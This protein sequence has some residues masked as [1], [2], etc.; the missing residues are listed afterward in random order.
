M[1]RLSVV[2]FQS[3][4]GVIQSVLSHDED[5]DGGFAHGGWVL[6]YIDETVADFMQRQTVAAGGLLL[7]R[8]TYEAF[9][10]VW[11]YADQ[12]EPAV[13][14]MNQIPKYV[15]STTLT[16]TSWANTVVLGRDVPAEVARLKKSKGGDLVVFGSSVLLR[17]LLAH[18]LVDTLHLLTFPIVLGTGKR[19]FS[20]L[21]A[22]LRFTLTGVTT[23]ASGVL[24]HSYV[25]DE[26]ER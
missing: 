18:D 26:F 15:V 25:A 16:E 22:P 7:G 10:A 4:D 6:P 19:M 3:L 13:A 20:D 8:K 5:R 14:A 17:T 9:A 24:F 21:R 12:T 23:S 2:N 11:P 1:A